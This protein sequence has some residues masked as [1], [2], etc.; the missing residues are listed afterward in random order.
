MTYNHN[1]KGA[2]IPYDETYIVEDTVIGDNVWFG[3][4]VIV[5]PGVTIGE[6]AIIQAGSVVTSDVSAL[7]IVGGH[8]ARQFSTRDA[9]HY[10]T[11]KAQRKFY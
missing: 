3:L 9:D 7:A 11:L 5:L 8:P 10:Q 1:Y 4:D 6:G 2:A